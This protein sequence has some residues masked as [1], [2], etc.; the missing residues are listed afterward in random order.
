M[1]RMSILDTAQLT[2]WATLALAIFALLAAIVA[3]AAWRVQAKQLAALREVNAKQLPVLAA[4]LG[5]MKVEVG[6]RE[7]Q[8]RERHEQFV[9][10]IFCWQYIGPERRASKTEKDAG[11]EPIT[12]CVTYV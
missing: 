5:E 3:G 4:Q 8:E 2:A 10:Q 1:P 11:I 9:A 6:L 12:L 7:R